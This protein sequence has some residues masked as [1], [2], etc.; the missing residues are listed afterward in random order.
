[1]GREATNR[2]TIN[3]CYLRQMRC[4][5][6][7][8]EEKGVY[9]R[10][11]FGH[12]KTLFLGIDGD[13]TKNLL[14]RVADG[15]VHGLRP[16]VTVILIGDNHNPLNPSRNANRNWVGRHRANR[17]WPLNDGQ[18]PHFA[19]CACTHFCIAV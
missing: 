13:L 4:S 1:V 9:C 6:K 11:E 18:T 15:E 12:L 3:C 19:A 2:V 17:K 14:Y 10:S 5:W 16:V 8:A 7:N